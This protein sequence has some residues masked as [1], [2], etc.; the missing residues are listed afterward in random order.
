MFNTK[1]TNYLN[2]E[3]QLDYSLLYF[4]YPIP[5]CAKTG[6]RPGVMPVGLS[7]RKLKGLFFAGS[8]I[9]NCAELLF[10]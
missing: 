4:T 7:D 6:K 8:F 1:G 3:K 9:R 2:G 5:R 10:D